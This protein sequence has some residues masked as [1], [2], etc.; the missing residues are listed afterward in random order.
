MNVASSLTPYEAIGGE[1]GIQK[2]VYR[3]YALMDELPEAYMVRKMH[4]ESLAGSAES[5]FEFLSGWLGG[6]PLY[7]NQKGHPRLRMRHAPYAVDQAVRNEWMQ[8]MTQAI[9]E[10]VSDPQFRAWLLARF[11]QMA[12]HMIDTESAPPCHFGMPP[13]A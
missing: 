10:Q 13:S 11:A 1:A 4:P 9:E 8:C 6:P 5:L 7:A 3:F 12:S 2:M